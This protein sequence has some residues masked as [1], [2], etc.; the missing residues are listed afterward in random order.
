M[1]TDPME[2]LIVRSFQGRTSAEE[3][4]RLRSWRKAS[5]ENERA[6]ARMERLWALTSHAELDGPSRPP[7]TARELMASRRTP[8]AQPRGSW[9]RFTRRALAAAALV[10]LGIGIARVWIDRT[11][12]GIAQFATGE[13]EMVTATLSDG[14]LVQL[15]PQSRLRF[16]NGDDERAAWLE[17]Q[18]FFAVAENAAAPFVVRTQL[19]AA[20]V[21]GTRFDL[22]VDADELQLAVVEGKVRLAAS[23]AE[24][25]VSRGELSRV[26][27]GTAPTLRMVDDIYA[28]VDWLGATFVFQSTPLAEVLEEIERRF[29]H[30][31]ELADSALA[32]RTVTAWF[33][34][35]P[36]DEVVTAVCRVVQA[37][38]TIEEHGATV[39]G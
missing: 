24:I 14:T 30:P 34:N 18:A 35:R 6:F 25:D 26:R 11:S 5:P 12:A 17:G 37:T 39:G 2:H 32:G 15:A 28:Y 33:T 29:G 16:V 31:V 19:G 13:S 3:E 22:R 23:D 21:L 27:R 10:I 38:C 9:S 36:F 7:P 1:V 4:D 20:S 8:E